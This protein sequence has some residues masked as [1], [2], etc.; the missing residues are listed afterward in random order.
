MLQFIHTVKGDG[1][2][3]ANIIKRRINHT[4]ID[5]L[6]MLVWL[7]VAFYDF[8]VFDPSPLTLYI[9]C[10]SLCSQPAGGWTTVKLRH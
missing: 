3:T 2:K 9:N 7:I 5:I 10:C 8:A 4:N 1:S 6:A